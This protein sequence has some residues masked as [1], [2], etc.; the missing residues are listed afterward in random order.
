MQGDRPA[1]GQIDKWI[2]GSQ[3]GSIKCT[4]V[5]VEDDFTLTKTTPGLI[6]LGL[7][8]PSTVRSAFIAFFRPVGKA[9][10]GVVSK[11]PR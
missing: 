8:N 1:V 7:R 10:Q 4:K 3:L 6:G 5:L 11:A 2:D 9:F